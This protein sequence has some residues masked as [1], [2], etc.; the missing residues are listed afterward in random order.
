MIIIHDH[1]YDDYYATDHD[2]NDDDDDGNDDNDRVM[3][4][5][6]HNAQRKQTP[7]ASSK[8]GINKKSGQSILS[9]DPLLIMLL[10][11]IN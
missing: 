10:V 1:D 2:D 3:R 5:T 8:S 7:L 9:T 11:I 4:Q 6:V